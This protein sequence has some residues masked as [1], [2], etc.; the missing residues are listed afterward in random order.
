MA[1]SHASVR[2][3]LTPDQRTLLRVEALVL[4]VEALVHSAKLSMEEAEQEAESIKSKK[5][6][7][8]AERLIDSL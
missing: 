8:Q 2:V 1:E 7:A 6:R 5:L 4:R 3:K